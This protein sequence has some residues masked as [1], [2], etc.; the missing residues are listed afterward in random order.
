MKSLNKHIYLFALV[1][2]LASVMSSCSFLEENQERPEPAVHPD[3]SFYD[4]TYTIG[5]PD[6]N[7]FTI[8]AKDLQIYKK[9]DRATGNII[10]FEQRDDEGVVQV[11]GTCDSI[12]IDTDDEDAVLS[13]N[14]SLNI[15]TEGLNIVSDE[16]TWDSDT[17]ILDTGDQD[18]VV[19]WSN[20]NTIA[21]KGFT[22]NL[23]TRDFELASIE[24]G[25]INEED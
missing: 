21:G 7:P 11:S 18:V 25:I 12:S 1:L 13:G 15:E 6:G 9:E 16:V 4:A 2:S 10:T 23:E 3:L 20:G 8:K 17:S 22:A 14:V 24:E 19:T 5:R